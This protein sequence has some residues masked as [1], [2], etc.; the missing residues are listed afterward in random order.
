MKEDNFWDVVIA[1]GIRPRESQVTSEWT[2]LSP[3]ALRSQEIR[4]AAPHPGTGHGFLPFPWET[5]VPFAASDK[6][7]SKLSIRAQLRGC[8]W[9]ARTASCSLRSLGISPVSGG[10]VCVSCFSD[11]PRTLCFSLWGIQEGTWANI[12][13]RPLFFRA[14][15]IQRTWDAE[16]V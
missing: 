4:L 1:V 16:D 9:G 10:W 5:L 13:W 11:I 3:A 15:Q 14:S 2:S 12:P 8:R 6:E 7:R